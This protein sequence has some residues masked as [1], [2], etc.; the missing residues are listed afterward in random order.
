MV[1]H[2]LALA[3]ALSSSGI[4][5]QLAAP[6][7]KF[8]SFEVAA[9]RPVDS[10][11]KSSRYITMRG[12]DTFVEKSY[13]LKLLI[14]A[15]YELNPRE[16]SGGPGWVG[17]DHFDIQARTPGTVRPTHEEQMRMLR[18]LLTDRFKL[19]YHRE[20]RVFS[21]Y[22]LETDKG[23]PKLKP[24]T[25]AADAPP[26]LISTVYPQH[27]LLPARN[28]TMAE[29]VSILQRAILDRPVVDKTGLQGRYDFDL[30]W[31][32]EE[33]QFGGEVPATP[34]D[35]S[36]PPFFTAVREQLGLRMVATRGPAEALVID[37]V[38][39]PSPN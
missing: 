27:I 35:A 21:I 38:Q 29:F 36:S 16:I 14:A 6:R 11:R 34:Q 10:D 39:R 15:A 24:S 12:S 31:A 8:D 9:I 7:P 20:Q 33:T 17:S 19:S 18:R 22:E 32:P 5:P 23:G 25:A 3:L 28:A 4:Q 2:I 13:T 30:Q 37:R 1:P 26:A